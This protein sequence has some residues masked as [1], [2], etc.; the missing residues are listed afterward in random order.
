MVSD[1]ER[2]ADPGALVEEA[3]R[4]LDMALFLDPTS[5]SLVARL[6]DALEAVIK[7]GN[8]ANAGLG[9]LKAERDAARAEAE[10]QRP[11]NDP[12]RPWLHSP[13][14]EH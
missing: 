9:T 11:F 4:Y 6:A 7:L 14:E 2:A 13:H 10:A 12:S 3:R 1:G 5:C 8:I